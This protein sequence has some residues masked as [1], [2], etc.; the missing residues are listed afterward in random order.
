MVMEAYEPAAPVSCIFGSKFSTV[1]DLVLPYKVDLDLLL[2]SSLITTFLLAE[3]YRPL[4]EDFN[5]EAFESA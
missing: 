1:P 2:G 4:S 3:D 5:A